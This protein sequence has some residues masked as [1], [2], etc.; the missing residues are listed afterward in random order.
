MYACFDQPDLKA[1]FTLHRDRARADWEV[2]SNV[3]RPTPSPSR[4][5]GARAAG[6]SRRPRA[7]STYIT[8]LVA[9]PYHEVTD[10]TPRRRSTARPA[11]A[12]QSLAEHLDADEIFDDHQAGLRLLP[13]RRSAAVP[14]RQ[15]RPAVRARV[16]RGR[17]GERRLRDVPARTTSS[18]PR[19][20][21]RRDERRARDDPARDGAHVVRRPGHHAL[22]G[23]PVAERVV[24]DVRVDAVARPRRPAGR[25]AWTTFAQRREDLGLPAG[26]AALDAPDRRRHPRHRGGRGQL[27]RHH[28]RQG[29]VGPQAARRLGRPGR[30]PRRRARR[31]SPSTP[32][33]TPRSPTCSAR[34]RRPP[35]A[36]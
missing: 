21:T 9:G 34:W 8:A 11:T 16:Q 30:V 1:T 18:A 31:T 22:V 19:S 26:P 35:A 27:R 15:V 25:T 5:P 12:A 33:A 17:D 6:T 24:R 28:L 29:R 23:R 20:P 3:P 10:T 36:T 4:P 7:M 14:V 2:V 32:G 13:R